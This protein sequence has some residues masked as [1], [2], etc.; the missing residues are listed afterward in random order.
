MA[1]LLGLG[2]EGKQQAKV[3]S[4]AVLGYKVDFGKVF[5][6]EG[7]NVSFNLGNDEAVD[8][9]YSACPDEGVELY[10]AMRAVHSAHILAGILKGGN[11]QTIS[12]CKV[13]EYDRYGEDL[14]LLKQLVREYAPAEYNRF[15][16]GAHYDDPRWK[17]DY[18]PQ[19]ADG[20]T[21]YNLGTSKR[22]YDDFA[23][24]V[25]K[26][27]AGTAAEEDPR[28]LA[29]VDAFGEGVFLRR[30]KT[31][32]NGS[33][34]YQLHLEEMRAIIENQGKH[35]PFLLE[36][37]DKLE[38]LVSFR[39]PYYV[40]PLTTKNAAIN[41]RT[42]ERRFA[43]SERQAGQEA[44]KVYPWNWEEVID[45]DKSASDASSITSSA[46][47]RACRKSRVARFGTRRFTRRKTARRSCRFR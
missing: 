20:Y 45:K 44:T 16:R 13:R 14:R 29:M 42:G 6:V 5:G 27:F 32:D 28:Y 43:W 33:I 34:P 2:A 40:G 1:P 23:K 38:S 10:E 24:D 21:R 31:S 4:G 30:L 22:S 47:S 9:F 15:F 26:L 35:Y 37:R 7:D 41:Y 36:E 18:D 3:L 46:T 19:K 39:I 11:G 25:K 12:Y 8:A 17:K